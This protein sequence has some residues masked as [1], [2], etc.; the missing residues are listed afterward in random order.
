MFGNEA[1]WH[2]TQFARH[3]VSEAVEMGSLSILYC[4]NWCKHVL[5]DDIVWLYVTST[6]LSALTLANK[7]PR[8]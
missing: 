5:E 3:I 8:V 2:N 1:K 6:A 7:R 4:G